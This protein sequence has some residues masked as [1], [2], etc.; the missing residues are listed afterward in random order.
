[1]SENIL[2]IADGFIFDMDGVLWRSGQQIGNL[3][4][5]FYHLQKA[6]K[7]FVFASNNSTK[8]IETYVQRFLSFGINIDRK[9]IITSAIATALHLKEKYPQGGEVFV[10]GENGLNTALFAQGFSISDKNPIA[11]IVGLDTQLTFEKL[12]I[13]TLLIRKGVDFIGSN[14]DRSFPSAEGLTPGAGAI[15]AAL[16]AATDISPTIIGKPY[17]RLIELAF[18]NMRTE[19]NRTV[20]IGDRLETDIL[21]GSNAGFKTALVLSGVSNLEDL[22]SWEPKPDFVAKDLTDLFE[23]GG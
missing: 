6:G 8:P 3:S 18:N 7:Q 4:E 23:L 2:N 20:F 11:V 10:I 19:R 9:K 16:E 14:P 17:P 1:M 5:I 21:G 12:R 22:Q 13:A 15:L